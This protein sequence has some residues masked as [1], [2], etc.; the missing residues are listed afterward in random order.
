[1]INDK[2]LILSLIAFLFSA[3]TFALELPETTKQLATSLGLVYEG[4]PKEKLYETGFT[5]LLQKGYRQEGNDEWIT[6]SDWTTEERG[7]LITFHLKDGKV[8]DWARPKEKVESSE[9]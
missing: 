2:K 3:T 5:E 4:M 7:D 6:F 9:I 8:V 1:M